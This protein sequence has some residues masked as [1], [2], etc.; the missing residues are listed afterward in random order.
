MLHIIHLLTLMYVSAHPIHTSSVLFRAKTQLLHH[1][2]INYCN[3]IQ[4]SSSFSILLF[5]SACTDSEY[6]IC[7][8]DR[9]LSV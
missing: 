5:P 6:S 3:A 2:G 1:K 8:G 9:G 7:V 4:I